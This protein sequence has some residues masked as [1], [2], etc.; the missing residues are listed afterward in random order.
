LLGEIADRLLTRSSKASLVKHLCN[1]SSYHRI[2]GSRGLIEA[3]EYIR[4]ELEDLGCDVEFLKFSYSTPPRWA[5]RLA[6]WDVSAAELWVTSPWRKRIHSF[7]EIPTSVVA[8]S[9]GGEFEGELKVVSGDEE[10]W[11][12]LADSV[13]LA[14]WRGTDRYLSLCRR[15]VKAV[16]F[17]RPGAPKDAVPYLG[18]FLSPEDLGVAKA[19]AFSVSLS[20]AVKLRAALR[21]YGRVVLRGFVNSNFT[22]PPPCVVVSASFGRG[23]REAHLTAHYC[24]AAGLINDNASGAA[25]LMAMAESLARN[26]GG[27]V[28][29]GVLRLL[30]VPEYW[31]SLSYLQALEGAGGLGCIACSINLD[32][33]G[34]A[35][36]ITGSTLLMVRP[37]I[38]ML[39]AVEPLALKALDS[40]LGI[41]GKPLGP[42]GE[43]RPLSFSVSNFGSGSDHEPYVAYGIPSVS[44]INWP[45]RYYHTDLD[46]VSKFDP[47]LALSV[48]AAAT[49]ALVRRLQGGVSEVLVKNYVRL[50][51][52]LDVLRVSGDEHLAELRDLLYME[53]LKAFA[54]GPKP[55]K[56][57]GGVP[58]LRRLLKSVEGSEAYVLRRLGRRNWFRSAL[59]LTLALLRGGAGC[60][61]CRLALQAELGVRIR[62]SEYNTILSALERLGAIAF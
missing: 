23:D 3:A 48:A 39:D 6:G 56:V 24:H 47:S 60:V 22:S 17:Y 21:K 10:K 44:L 43:H 15:G 62:E 8:H 45:D 58:G 4:D 36:Q 33:I 14:C 16:L 12:D 25:A 37:P 38:H 20:T 53:G 5:L 41:L 40:T 19:P 29:G 34:E 18:L 2:Q 42:T 46:D 30:W 57:L 50:A 55:S 1:I 27:L 35:Q 28:R 59:T 54:E 13:V 31:G 52:G 11:G 7:P 26:D 51:R 32:M 49:E 61:G 9:P